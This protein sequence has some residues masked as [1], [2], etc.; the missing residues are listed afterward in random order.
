MCED[1]CT[2]VGA[3]CEVGWTGETFAH[4]GPDVSFRKGATTDPLLFV[5]VA[6]VV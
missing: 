2:A 6:V 4:V 1:R 5:G 3:D